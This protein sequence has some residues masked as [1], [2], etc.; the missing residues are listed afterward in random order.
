MTTLNNAQN[1][2]FDVKGK[3]IETQ[4]RFDEIVDYNEE[5]GNE[6]N[7]ITGICVNVMGDIGDNGSYFGQVQWDDQNQKY[8][9]DCEGNSLYSDVGAALLSNF[10]DSDL[11]DKH[12]IK[13]DLHRDLM[14]D[15]LPE[16]IKNIC[17]F[18]E[19]HADAY[20]GV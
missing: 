1:N 6:E 13:S 7:S 19:A 2:T 15:V 14:Y 18:A 20:R 4:V 5:H 17:N 9:T 12:G 10:D 3:E 11:Y 16:I 8:S